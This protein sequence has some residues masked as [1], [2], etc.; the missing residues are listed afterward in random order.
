[1]YNVHYVRGMYSSI[2]K[3]VPMLKVRRNGS[4]TSFS[5]NFLFLGK[6]SLFADA[7]VVSYFYTYKGS[8]QSHMAVKIAMGCS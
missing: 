7:A 5:A 1:M 3:Q 8:S 2:V 4:K 6:S